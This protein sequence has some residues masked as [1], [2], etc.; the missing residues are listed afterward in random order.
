MVSQALLQQSSHNEYVGY[1]KQWRVYA[2]DIGIIEI[3]YVLNYFSSMF[4]KRVVS[5]TINNADCVAVTILHILTYQSKNKHPLVRKYIAER[6]KRKAHNIL[7]QIHIALLLLRGTQRCYTIFMFNGDNITLND[8]S[9][10]F[11]PNK[12]VKYSR[13]GKPVGKLLK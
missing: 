13:K 7:T 10:S 11:L 9:V 2:K 1:M 3:H 4:D 6:L 12:I 5:F 8:L